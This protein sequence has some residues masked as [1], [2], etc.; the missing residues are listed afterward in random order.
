MVGSRI[1]R[2][3]GGNGRARGDPGGRPAA[4][5]YFFSSSAEITMRCASLVPS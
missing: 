1:V 3:W 4:N 2:G 5:G